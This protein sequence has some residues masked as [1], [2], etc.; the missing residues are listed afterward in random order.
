MASRERPLVMLL[1][2]LNQLS[3]DHRAHRLNWLP[4]TLPANV[5]LVLST[6]TNHPTFHALQTMASWLPESSVDGGEEAGY[7]LEVPPL[8]H[9]VS[10]G[11][12]QEWLRDD[13]RALTSQQL[14]IVKDALKHCSLPL[15]T[16]LVCEEVSAVAVFLSLSDRDKVYCALMRWLHVKDKCF[17]IVLQQF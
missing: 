1:D 2:G 15:Y 10:V 4:R 7:L 9:D 8:S 13:G 16:S 17:A 11:L 6:D 12:V 5:H 14:Q 3:F